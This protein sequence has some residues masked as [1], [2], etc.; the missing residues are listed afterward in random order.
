MSSVSLKASEA[1]ALSD[2]VVKNQ[3]EKWCDRLKLQIHLRS[4]QSEDPFLYLY[5]DSG[6]ISPKVLSMVKKKMRRNGYRMQCVGT[7]GSRWDGVRT[8]RYF[9]W[10][11][12]WYGYYAYRLKIG[13]LRFLNSR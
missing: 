6:E 11:G 8:W 13:W 5:L 9:I 3:M 12:S 7:L 2:A 4:T 1:C 10:W